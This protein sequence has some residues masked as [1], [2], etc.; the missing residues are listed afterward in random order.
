MELLAVSI[1]R[2]TLYPI[3]PRLTVVRLSAL[4]INGTIY[5]NDYDADTSI[6]PQ[7]TSTLGL[8]SANAS[9]SK[10]MACGPGASFNNLTG[11]IAVASQF[12]QINWS[13]GWQSD[14]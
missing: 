6:F 1:P 12:I 11:A 8:V 2:I 10:D 3:V 13:S 14:R 9:K 7:L 5:Q 4:R